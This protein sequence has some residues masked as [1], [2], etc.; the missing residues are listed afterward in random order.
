MA[1][2]LV[3]A[4]RLLELAA[5]HE[6]EKQE[7]RAVVQAVSGVLSCCVLCAVVWWWA[8]VQAV[9]LRTNKL[10]VWWCTQ[11]C[12]V[13]CCVCVVVCSTVVCTVVYSAVVW[14]GVLSCGVVC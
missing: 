2:W 1:D 7:T 13:W 14:C 6:L 3:V 4:Q 12:S 8:V 11:H 10:F 5:D 9:S